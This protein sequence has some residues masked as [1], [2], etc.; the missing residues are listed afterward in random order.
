MAAQTWEERVSVDQSLPIP[1]FAYTT[2][3]D[4][5]KG[6]LKLKV[7]TSTLFKVSR[8]HSNVVVQKTPLLKINHEKKDQKTI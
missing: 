5:K 2:H 3:L 4:H 1:Q 8:C 6:R 7:V